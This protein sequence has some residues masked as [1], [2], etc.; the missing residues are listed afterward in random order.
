M[1]LTVAIALAILVLPAGD[2]EAGGNGDYPPPSSGHWYIYQPTSVWSEAIEMQGSIY[3]Y[4]PLTLNLVDLTMN[5]S[6]NLQFEIYVTSTGSLSFNNGNIT[7][8]DTT[9][10]YRFRTYNTTV[11]RNSEIS[12]AYY[13]LEV[14]TKQFT[15]TDTKV[16]HM[17]SYGVSMSLVYTLTGDVLIEDN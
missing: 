9:Y 4:A 6:W 16:F 1:L 14:F 7:A 12:E 11:I 2:A 15:L 17:N 5:C 3:V 13:G 8:S 10:H